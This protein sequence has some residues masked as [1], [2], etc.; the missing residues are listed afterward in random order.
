VYRE[1]AARAKTLAARGDVKGAEQ[2]MR[3]G[4]IMSQPPERN[5][6]FSHAD[7]D[8]AVAEAVARQQAAL[9]QGASEGKGWEEED[10][11]GREKLLQELEEATRRHE[12]RWSASAVGG[13]GGQERRGGTTDAARSSFTTS[14]RD[15]FSSPPSCIVGPTARRVMLQDESSSVQDGS[16]E[17]NEGP[18]DWDDVNATHPA[19][20]GRY[21]RVLF[22]Y[23]IRHQYWG[24]VNTLHLLHSILLRLGFKSG[25][26]RLT[27]QLAEAVSVNMPVIPPLAG[28]K[29]SGEKLSAPADEEG[30]VYDVFSSPV[31]GDDLVII[32]EI[33]PDERKSSEYSNTGAR[34]LKYVLS[35]R[36]QEDSEHPLPADEQRRAQE[37]LEKATSTSGDEADKEDGAWQLQCARS[38]TY[39]VS[40]PP[41]PRLRF[42]LY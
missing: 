10:Q 15:E 39:P 37:K 25:Y 42:P 22:D 30:G 41:P 7:L 26:H 23:D 29:Q 16:Q 13:K 17:S 11:A 14:L 2:L 36:L 6:G 9:Q 21:G 1:L 5:A 34:V 33:F 4:Q 12:Q 18:Q 31:D 38:D 3:V 8:A 35:D 19:L 32:P 24:G 40:A 20:V 27:P 28:E